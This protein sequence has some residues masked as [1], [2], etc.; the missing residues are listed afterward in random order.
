MADALHTD[1][2]RDC[3]PCDSSA[4]T[5][6]DRQYARTDVF[7]V[8]EAIIYPLVGPCNEPIYR[9]V[10]V[11]NLSSHG[12]GITLDDPLQPRQKVE[13]YIEKQRLVGEVQWCRQIQPKIHLV[14]CRLL[15]SV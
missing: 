10:M 14:G 11:L 6:L 3:K 9:A 8:A 1:S 13:L 2:E 7:S 15:D 5:E 12:F 4:E